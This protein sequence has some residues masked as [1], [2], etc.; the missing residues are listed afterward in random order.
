MCHL[1]HFQMNRDATQNLS[2]LL[3]YFMLYLPLIADNIWHHQLREYIDEYAY[4][5]RECEY[6]NLCAQRCAHVCSKLTPLA[7]SFG[8]STFRY[9][10]S[11]STFSR[12]TTFS[13][14]TDPKAACTRLLIPGVGETDDCET[15]LTGRWKSEFLS[16]GLRDRAGI[17]TDEVAKSEQFVFIDRRMFWGAVQL[18]YTITEHP[19]LGVKVCIVSSELGYSQHFS[20]YLLTIYNIW[21]PR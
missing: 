12:V 8:R 1:I 5:S 19:N 3:T 6:N 17:A 4:K 16:S 9:S 7:N 13:S 14:W 10:I 18:E 11:S 21:P 2:G 20:A 15:C